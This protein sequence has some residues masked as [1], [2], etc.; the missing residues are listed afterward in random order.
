MRVVEVRDD[1]IVVR[2]AKMSITGVV[3]SEE[4]IVMPTRAMTEKDADYAVS[5]AVPS[6][7]R[8]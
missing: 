8:A 6:T 7:P 5:F 3:T 1:G 4:L 2:D